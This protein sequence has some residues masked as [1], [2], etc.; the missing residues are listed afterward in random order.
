MDHVTHTDNTPTLGTKR[1]ILRP[2]ST[3]DAPALHRISNEPLVRRYLWTT[4]RTSAQIDEVS[5]RARVGFTR[6]A[7]DSLV[8]GCETAQNRSA[9]AG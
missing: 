9:S 5:P 4:G 3:H 6:R 1:L 8:C 2:L 7:L